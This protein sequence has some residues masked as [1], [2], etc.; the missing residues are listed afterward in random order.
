MFKDL[1]ELFVI[2]FHATD[3]CGLV[4]LDVLHWLGEVITATFWSWHTEASLIDVVTSVTAT[5]VDDFRF[6]CCVQMV[7]T[8]GVTD[9][10]SSLVTKWSSCKEIWQESVLHGLEICRK[11]IVPIIIYTQLSLYVVLHMLEK[12]LV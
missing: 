7:L 9:L 8:V 6:T 1:D 10:D 11:D 2:P 12:K 3:S 5:V 4:W